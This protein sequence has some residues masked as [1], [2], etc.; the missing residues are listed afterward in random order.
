MH[1]FE[2]APRSLL[3]RSLELVNAASEARAEAHAVIEDEFA[4][5]LEGKELAEVEEWFLH[6][7]RE[8]LEALLANPVCENP[9]RPAALLAAVNKAQRAAHT[10][11]LHDER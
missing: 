3:S 4:E 1:Y 7:A 10:A 8:V 9:A 5:F 6:G 2:K 11:R